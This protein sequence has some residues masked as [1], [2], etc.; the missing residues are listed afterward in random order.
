VAEVVLAGAALLGLSEEVVAELAFQVLDECLHLFEV[1]NPVLIEEVFRVSS[2]LRLEAFMHLVAGMLGDQFSSLDLM[3]T[4]LAQQRELL[5]GSGEVVQH[6]ALDDLRS[7]ELALAALLLM[8][9]HLV[10]GDYLVTAKLTILA[11]E[12]DCLQEAEHV[13]VLLESH[14]LGVLV[15][16]V[17]TGLLLVLPSLDTVVTERHCLALVAE[18]RLL[19]I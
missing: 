16:A 7:A 15:S 18:L 6:L 14:H 2:F 12:L 10:V 17:G 1:A 13:D 19:I 5:A 11:V 8:L 9:F 3:G 4:E